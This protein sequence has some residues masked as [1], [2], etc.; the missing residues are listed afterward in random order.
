M[1]EDCTFVFSSISTNT[2]SS[3]GTMKYVL[4][5]CVFLIETTYQEELQDTFIASF[6]SSGKWT[7]DEYLEYNGNIP[8]L[9]EFTSCHWEKAKFFSE[10][11]SLIWSYCQHFSRFQ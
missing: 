8:A 3:F 6:Q 2:I 11:E 1:V 7:A 9:R 10:K 5:A 4:I